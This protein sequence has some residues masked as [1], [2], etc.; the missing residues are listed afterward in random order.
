MSLSITSKALNISIALHLIWCVFPVQQSCISLFNL[1]KVTILLV[2][3]FRWQLSGVMSIILLRFSFQRQPVV[4]N[5]LQRK[6]LLFTLLWQVAALGVPWKTQPLKFYV[7]LGNHF[8]VPFYP[9]SHL[10]QWFWFLLQNCIGIFYRIFLPR[11]LFYCFEEGPRY[12][13]SQ[14]STDTPLQLC[15]RPEGSYGLHD[16]NFASLMAGNF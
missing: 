6:L 1:T 9:L 14:I 15:L 5:S 4:L 2:P 12:Q 8:M 16:Y 7:L 3:I 10:H 11:A 13:D